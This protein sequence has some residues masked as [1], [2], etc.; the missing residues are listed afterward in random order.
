MTT[1]P[2]SVQTA[3]VRPPRVN[4]EIFVEVHDFLVDEAE[5][6]DD[7]LHREW[8][9][10]L[11]DDV[12]YRMPARRSVYRRDGTGVDFDNCHFDDDWSSLE[13]RVRRSVEITS[14]FDRDP[15]PRMRRLVTNLSVRET[16]VPDEFAATSSIL[17]LRNRLHLQGYDMLSARRE[18]V[19]RRT[20]AGLRLAKRLI[21]VDQ[22]TLSA[23]FLNVFL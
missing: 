10:L 22:A 6:L 1:A 18:D 14:A 9:G 17:L 20:D 12:V 11:T 21:L 3:A 5:L 2:E 16:E 8:L 23:A 19:V 7:D 15:A 4:T 13:M